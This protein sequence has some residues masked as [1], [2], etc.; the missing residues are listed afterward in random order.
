MHSD[1][2]PSQLLKFKIPMAAC[3]TFLPRL[4]QGCS[5]IRPRRSSQDRS[6]VHVSTRVRAEAL[7]QRQD[8]P[9][10]VAALHDRP[11]NPH[12]DRQGQEPLA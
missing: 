9:P 11:A 6:P 4:L 2:S 12:R 10:R 3:L 8:V 1:L 7:A 5:R